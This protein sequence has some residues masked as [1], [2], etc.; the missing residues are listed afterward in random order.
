MQIVPHGREAAEK[1]FD[2]ALRYV[3]R[4]QRRGGEMC[5]AGEGW[6]MA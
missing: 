2:D 5:V 4:V 6:F 1:R 3:I